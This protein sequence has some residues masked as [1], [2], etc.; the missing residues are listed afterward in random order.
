MVRVMQAKLT[1]PLIFSMTA[2]KDPDHPWVAV[3][4][5]NTDGGQLQK[6]L[7]LLNCSLKAKIPQI[8]ITLFTSSTF[9]KIY[10][11]FLPTGRYFRMSLDKSNICIHDIVLI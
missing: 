3:V 4:A 10:S 6:T 7:H 1:V 5:S 9:S 11:A 2:S 8:Q